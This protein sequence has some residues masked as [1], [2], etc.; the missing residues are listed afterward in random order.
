MTGE[1]MTVLGVGALAMLCVRV[2]FFSN[3][4]SV[5]LF[6]SVVIGSY[7]AEFYLIYS[8]SP[9]GNADLKRE[10]AQRYGLPF[11]ARP[12]LQV[13][14]D[15]RRQGVDAHPWMKL[16]IEIKGFETLGNSPNRTIVFC[17]E[18]GPFT[19][20][21][22]DRHGFNNPD[23][24]WDSA[25]V[26]LLIVGDSFT[27]GHCAPDNNG[28]VEQ[29]RAELG[30]SIINLGLARNGALMNLGGI[31]EYASIIRPKHILWF[32]YAG[33]DLKN[34]MRAYD[35][36][37]FPGYLKEGFSQ[38][39]YERRVEIEML[40][41]T[42]FEDRF[43][44][45]F[46][47]PDTETVS[48]QPSIFQTREGFVGFLKLTKVRIGLGF[49]RYLEHDK[50]DFQLFERVMQ[51]AKILTTSVGAELHFINIPNVH[52]YNKSRDSEAFQVED[53]I[54]QLGIP[55]YNLRP[56]LGAEDYKKYWAYGENGGHF[57][58]EGQKR[59][60][61]WLLLDVIPQL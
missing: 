16:P 4:L 48:R 30:K 31:A 37:V 11:D 21:K 26:E 23:A 1:L 6:S 57:S 36:P 44:P 41:Q 32:H 40:M 25:Q 53:I 24:V 29:V 59:V 9:G 10:A 61:K 39:L 43:E 55:Y 5:I 47:E 19:L 7:S 35:S 28:F 22:S 27:Q 12:P 8:S 50:I 51:R 33:N 58:P 52:P 14:R 60:A 54:Q 46:S 17:N 18:I 15:L 56:V 34:M 20:F 45:R 42:Y 49:A 2:P 38:N 3:T 13:V